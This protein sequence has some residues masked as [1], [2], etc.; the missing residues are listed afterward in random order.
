M[1]MDAIVKA[2]LMRKSSDELQELR[3]YLEA[4]NKHL[5]NQYKTAGSEHQTDLHN[6]I[7]DN[8]RKLFFIDEILTERGIHKKR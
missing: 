1:E 8:N 7:K 6:D 4:E 5:E 2:E 3:T